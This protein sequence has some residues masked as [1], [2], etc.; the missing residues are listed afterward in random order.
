VV[1]GEF[2]SYNG[3]TSNGL[4]VLNLDGS[5]KHSFGTSL[6]FGGSI[7]N[8]S[9][10]YD[11]VNLKHYVGGFFTSYNG[12]STKK[13]LIRF[14]NDWS[15]D[16][17]FN[18][19]GN[20]AVNRIEIRADGSLLISDFSSQNIKHVNTNGT[21]NTSVYSFGVGFNGTISDFFINPD[22][23]FMAF[24]GFTTYKTLSAGRIAQ[25][26]PT[27]NLNNC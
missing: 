23:S 1:V 17:S 2:T 20:D 3:I 10:T 8:L 27:G 13:K 11:S 26:S 21:I 22:G 7:E 16:N 15:I 12:D 19:A 25:I 5:V 6:A 24:G 9:Y 18:Y 4:V 14:N